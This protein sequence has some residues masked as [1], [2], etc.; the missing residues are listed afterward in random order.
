MKQKILLI[1]IVILLLL[2][3]ASYRDIE[4][5][6]SSY[7]YKDPIF[8]NNTFYNWKGY[9]IYFSKPDYR[10]TPIISTLKKK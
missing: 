10:W 7:Y 8:F 2:S 1:P 6:N 3:C 9:Q 5:Y 4:R